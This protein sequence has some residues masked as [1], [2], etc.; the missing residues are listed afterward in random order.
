VP[1]VI[2]GE[3]ARWARERVWTT[4]RREKSLPYR[5]LGHPAGSIIIII[6]IITELII[7]RIFVIYSNP[8]I[9]VE[10]S[11]FSMGWACGK[12]GRTKN[13]Y[14]ILADKSLE[15][16]PPWTPRRKQKD[17]IKLGLRVIDFEDRSWKWLRIVNNC[18]R[19]YCRC[20][21]FVLCYHSVSWCGHS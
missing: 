12:D 2:V 13:A 1:L 19:W 10:K 15:K 6:I 16:C 11:R 20:C 5:P 21:S 18:G 3:E 4:W 17:N 14:R 8:N 9:S 7:R